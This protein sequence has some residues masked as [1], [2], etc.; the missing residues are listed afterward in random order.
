MAENQNDS[1]R[2]CSFCGRSENEVAFLVPGRDGK[3]YI[4]DSCISVCSEFI[5]EHLGEPEADEDTLT[6]ETLP[7]PKEI[8]A[9]LDEHVIGQEEGRG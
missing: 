4:C 3:C 2:H 1:L 6:F 8:K 9:M 5:D 7:R